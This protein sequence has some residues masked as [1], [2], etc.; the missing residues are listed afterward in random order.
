MM[1]AWVDPASGALV[2]RLDIDPARPVLVGLTAGP[3]SPAI[4]GL[5]LVTP[6]RTVALR[7]ICD[8]MMTYD[9]G[10]LRLAMATWAIL[11]LASSADRAELDD[12]L[13]DLA[14]DLARPGGYVSSSAPRPVR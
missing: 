2:V 4:G 1:E 7:V 11:L 6:G 14:V 13:C 12:R 3:V 9:A 8:G 10:R 5:D